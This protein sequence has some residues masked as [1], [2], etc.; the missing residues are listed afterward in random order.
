MILDM[1]TIRKRAY[2]RAGLVGN[3][4]DGYFGKTLSVVVRN[5]WAEATLTES[6]RLELVPGRE[7]EGRYGS[8]DEL[9]GEVRLHGYYGGLRLVKATVKRFAEYCRQEGRRLDDRNFTFRYES[10]IP[11]QVGLAGSSAIIVAV[12]RA[13]ME[14]YGV[15]IPC[16]VQPSLALAVES[17]ELGVAAGLQDRVV[18]VYEG[19]VYMDFARGRME[20]HAGLRCGVY[21]SLDSALLPPLYLAYSVEAGGPTEVFHD[22]LRGPFSAGRAGRA[23]GDAAAGRPGGRGPHG[24]DGPRRR[25]VSGN[26]WTP[27]STCGARSAGCRP[28]RRPWSSVPAARG[29]TAHFAGS[30]G[31]IIGTYPDA[32][33]LARLQSQLA[34]SAAASS[35][36]LSKAAGEIILRGLL[37]RLGKDL[38]GG[39]A[40]DQLAF[41]EERRVIGDAGGLLQVVG[42]DDDRV[43]AAQLADEVF[44]P[45]VE[46]GSSA[47]QGSSMRMISGWTAIARAMHSRWCWPPES[48]MAD[49]WRRSLASSQRP[50]RCRLF[51]TASSRTCRWRT[52]PIRS[53]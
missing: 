29:A 8:L 20:E 1:T 12:L 22:D 30:G 46:R 34:P 48:P 9:V 52:P 36:P 42:H 13:L 40:F 51:S 33:T 41:V 32:A 45:V 47:E 44:D 27:T 49:W 43:L 53:P 15:E 28:P 5:F 26:S 21:E 17:E 3:P 11:R 16:R 10:N 7:D 35:S 4:S 38:L 23:G 37:G 25:G 2:A 6:D 18:Q 24:P 31:A 39:A 19:L 50:A 14:F